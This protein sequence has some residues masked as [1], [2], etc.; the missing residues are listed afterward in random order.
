MILVKRKTLRVNSKDM[1]GPFSERACF[2]FY[3]PDEAIG[4]Y[5]ILSYE[6]IHDSFR[7]L[8]SG[9]RFML[10]VLL[11]SVYKRQSQLLGSVPT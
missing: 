5:M 6:H 2:N 10:H 3:R 8:F 1:Q 7:L 11:F 9:L 4:S